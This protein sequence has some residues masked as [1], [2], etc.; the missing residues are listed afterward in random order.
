MAQFHIVFTV[1]P[2]RMY[3]GQ[4]STVGGTRCACGNISLLHLYALIA[5]FSQN[6][7]ILSP[8]LFSIW[9]HDPFSFN[10]YLKLFQTFHFRQMAPT[11]TQ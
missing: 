5:F 7:F 3:I 2:G 9:S 6:I 10:L 1:W 8:S 11:A 4:N